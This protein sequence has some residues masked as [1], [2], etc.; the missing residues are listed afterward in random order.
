MLLND[1]YKS[2][3]LLWAVIKRDVVVGNQ[4]RV[5]I[6]YPV[7]HK[8]EIRVKLDLDESGKKLV[9]PSCNYIK[10]LNKDYGELRGL[11]NKRYQGF[12]LKDAEVHSLDL[13]NTS[14]TSEDEDD[15]YWIRAKLG[16]KDGKRQAAVWIGDKSNKKGE[17][18]QFLID[19]EDEQLRFDKTNKNPS[20][21]ISAVKVAFTN[22]TT[23]RKSNAK[24][25]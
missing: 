25:S 7:C 1:V 14:V 22:T 3:G 16:E 11:V 4:E 6:A 20:E 23:E 15:N 17:K 24:T 9:C 2:E 19:I 5:F 21:L 8:E 13:I 10:T 12:L 18:I